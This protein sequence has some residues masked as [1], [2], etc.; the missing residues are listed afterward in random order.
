MTAHVRIVLQARLESRRLPGKSLLPV[1]GLPM[2]VL[3][4][5]RAARTGM[6]L[7]VATSLSSADDVLVEICRAAGLSVYRGPL[8]DVYARYIGAT[9]DLEGSTIVV[10]ITADN[11]FPDADLIERLV[12]TL[13][14]SRAS[15]VASEWPGSGLPYG[16]SVEVFRM[17][18]LRGSRPQS[19]YDA[20]H[21]TS[22]LRRLK[23]TAV[24]RSDLTYAP[25][26]ATVDT[27]DDY[28][29][30]H[31]VFHGIE[32]PVDVGWHELCG[33]LSALPGAPQALVP[34]TLGGGGPQSEL[35]LG[36]A[37]FGMPYGIANATGVP[38]VGEILRIVHCAVDNG[39]THID[40]ARMYGQSEARI[41]AA[42]CGGW[43]QRVKLVTKL[44]AIETDD[45]GS[46]RT[47]VDANIFRSCHALRTD[48]LDV[49]LLH[50]A[51]T[52]LVADGAA[53]GRLVELRQEGVIGLLGVSVQTPPELRQA[54]SDPEVRLIQLPFN[55][56]DGRWDPTVLRGRPD[57]V[58]HARSVFLQGLLAG[59]P[60]SRWP[61]VSD[62]DPIV[63][64]STLNE[65][66]H[67][68]GR[69]NVADLAIAFVRAHPWIHSLVLG[70]ETGEQLRENLDLFAMPAL[71]E[72]ALMIVRQRLPRLPE[73]LVDPAKWPAS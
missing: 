35:T 15:Y 64:V 19:K 30:V 4:A 37:Q 27:L 18:A 52:R 11:V 41:G 69:R 28:C 7:V 39:I 22:A 2:V 73:T 38:D 14:S 61:S 47:A 17:E 12:A 16:V 43:R 56:L 21:V 29:R 63:L 34:C 55:I 13:C 1:G 48:H 70:M 24:F 32:D 40:T 72:A 10:R 60:T 50:H 25:L 62:T 31:Q 54:V 5:R 53:W 6:D 8:E 51:A 36:T 46:A 71:D 49:V 57:V 67:E 9:E 42:L 45:A 33:R 68:L 23:P 26:R 44:P 58:V 3:A 66:V 65:L 20:E 59:A